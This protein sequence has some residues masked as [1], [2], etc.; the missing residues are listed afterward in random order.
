MAQREKDIIS[1]L[2]PETNVDY[3]AGQLESGQD[4]DSLFKNMMGMTGEGAT[5]NA[6][7]VTDQLMGAFGGNPED[8]DYWTGQISKRLLPWHW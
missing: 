8:K 4:Y 3:W 7:A 6:G 2:F 1:K 5:A